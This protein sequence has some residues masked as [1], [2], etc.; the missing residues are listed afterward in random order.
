M[1]ALLALVM[2]ALGSF[3]APAQTRPSEGPKSSPAAATSDSAAQIAKE[4]A[5]RRS[6]GDTHLPDADQFTLGDRT[7]SAG[8]RVDGPIAVAKGNLDVYGT[9]DG[10]VV[11]LGGNLRVH[12][13]GRIIGDA[14]AA[15]GSVLID[16]G[17][18]EGQKRAVAI[19]RPAIPA[20]KPHE[21]LST[22]E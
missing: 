10:D 21:P 19:S 17:M 7:I 14:W 1:R 4:I 2:L 20:P 18:V 13:G 3:R 22:W 8:T 12:T 5:Q 11:V 16:G 9:V 15:G 6:E